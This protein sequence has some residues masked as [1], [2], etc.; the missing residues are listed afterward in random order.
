MGLVLDLAVEL[1]VYQRQELFAYNSNTV[2]LQQD[3]NPYSSPL[4][5]VWELELVADKAER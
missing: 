1:P 4:E 3:V 2:R 5:K